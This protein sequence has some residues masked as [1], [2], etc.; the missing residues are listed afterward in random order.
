ME[1]RNLNEYIIT[2]TNE[3][4]YVGFCNINRCN[5]FTSLQ[6]IENI[7]FETAIFLSEII[8]NCNIFQTIGELRKSQF[9]LIIREKSSPQ[10]KTHLSFQFE[11]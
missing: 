9:I 6:S 1:I 11:Y 3:S 8:V 7:S 4:I 5:V 10:A 2:F